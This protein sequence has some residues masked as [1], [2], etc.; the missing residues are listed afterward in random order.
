VAQF[1]YVFGNDSKKTWLG[2]KLRGDW[3]P[4]MLAT[5]RS[6]TLCPLVCCLKIQKFEYTKLQFCLW[7][8]MGVKFGLW[9]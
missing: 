1:R 5:I 9:Y 2:R 4:V 6:R 7:L 3:T 8:C